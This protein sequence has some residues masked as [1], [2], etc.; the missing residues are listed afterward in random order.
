MWL[1]Y[2]WISTAVWNVL[3]KAAQPSCFQMYSLF[4]LQSTSF[5]EV[6]SFVF[7]YLADGAMTPFA[8]LFFHI[9]FR[10]FRLDS[11]M[12]VFTFCLDSVL[13]V[14]LQSPSHQHVEDT[15]SL[16]SSG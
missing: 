13:K 6:A 12:K 4:Y 8:P 14:A 5:F 11:V 10:L 16:R 9:C 7:D 2:I 3:D 15:A 1:M